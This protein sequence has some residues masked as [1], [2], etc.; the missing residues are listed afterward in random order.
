VTTAA[1]PAV[2]TARTVRQALRRAR[3]RSGAAKPLGETLE[4]VYVALFGVAML[5]AIGGPATSRVLRDVEAR[6]A[7][8]SLTAAMVA[9]TLLA[10]AGAALGALLLVGPLVRDPADATWLLSSPVRRRGLLATPALLLLTIGAVAGAVVALIASVLV[11]AASIPVWCLTGAAGG[12]LTVGLAIVVQPRGHLRAGLRHGSTAL[13]GAAL[14][15]LVIGL[16]SDDRLDLAL[17]SGHGWALVVVAPAL[18][19]LALVPPTLD[20]LRRQELTAGAGL[21]LGLRATV[22]TLDGSFV[23]ETLRARRLLERGL[24]RRRALAGQRWVALVV[25][26]VRRVSRSP[27]SLLVPV[28]L[29][30]VAWMVSRLYGDI[31]GATAV[32][33]VGWAAAG[34]SCAGLRTVSRSRSVARA[35]P[36]SDVD[37]RAA[38]CMVPATAALLATTATAVLCGQPLWSLA[39]ATA[40]AVAGVLRTSAGRP[41]VKWELQTASPM[42]AMP[43][44]AVMSY[45]VG[46]DVVALTALPLL[47]GLDPMICLTVPLGA[48]LLLIRRG[49]RED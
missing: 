3:R 42:G 22:T 33:L 8:P 6:A 41:P 36:L 11:P 19:V 28:A 23:A 38:H 39:P 30:P 17:P 13:T 21:A 14:V 5:I 2:P 29:V 9:A 32:V 47:I 34:A 26:D 37:L 16:A 24:V 44:G 25:A 18:A 49:R 4:D 20:R 12:V 15:V 45:A 1:P 31:A 46:I 7:S 48:V 40:C 10:A 43:V 35:L 27:R